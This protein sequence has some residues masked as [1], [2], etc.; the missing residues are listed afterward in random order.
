MKRWLYRPLTGIGGVS[1][2]MGLVTP[3]VWYLFPEDLYH[4]GFILSIL[5]WLTVMLTLYNIAFCFTRPDGA[6]RDLALGIAEV[7]GLLF[8]G[9]C[10]HTVMSVRHGLRGFDYGVAFDEGAMALPFSLTVVWWLLLLSLGGYVVLRFVPCERVTRSVGAFSVA[11]V[12][13]GI[14]LLVLLSVQWG[15]ES[16]VTHIFHGNVILLLGRALCDFFRLQK[17]KSSNGV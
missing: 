9:L 1:L 8:G 13:M 4:P 16:V 7:T 5:F 2:V 17:N 12:L 3:W 11:A 15:R 6:E 10:Y 14:L